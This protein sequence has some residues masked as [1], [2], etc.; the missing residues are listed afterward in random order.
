MSFLFG[1]VT[2][3]TQPTKKQQPNPPPSP[4]LLFPIFLYTSIKD[5]RKKFQRERSNLLSTLNIIVAW[6]SETLQIR[7]ETQLNTN[8]ISQLI[9]P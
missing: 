7:S 6:Q 9:N 5:G 1:F 2:T 4:I 8:V 3:K